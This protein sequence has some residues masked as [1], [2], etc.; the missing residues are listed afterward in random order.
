MCVGSLCLYITLGLGIF[1]SA[2]TSNSTWSQVGQLGAPGLTT[3][4]VSTLLALTI[5]LFSAKVAL[6]IFVCALVVVSSVCLLL[7][8]VPD[9]I[10]VISVPT[11]VFAAYTAYVLTEKYSR[12]HR[13]D[14]KLKPYTSTQLTNYYMS[15]PEQLEAPS[16]SREITILFCDIKNFTAIS[17]NLDPDCLRDWL[18]MYFH[19]VSVVIDRY[20]GTV[21]KYMGDSVM[22]FWGAPWHSKTHATDALMASMQIQKELAALSVEMAEDGLPPIEAGIGICTGYANVGLMGSDFHR[23]YTA[24]GDPVNTANRM[25]RCASLYN[26]DVVISESTA[27]RAPEYLLR[28][29]DTVNVKGRQKFVRLFEPVCH[30]DDATP[31]LISHIDLH[32]KAMQFYR[33]GMWLDAERLFNKLGQRNASESAYYQTYLERIKKIRLT[34]P[35]DKQAHVVDLSQQTG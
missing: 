17:E 28:E 33:G 9:V 27:E 16:E 18:N 34:R 23:T 8:V 10:A 31:E 19:K 3:L 4:V 11:A 30:L 35:K 21:D 13:I 32:C 25:Q 15:H 2:G 29:L 12:H 20:N 14:K 24:V 22:A 7:S 5:G 6:S 1:D 26:R